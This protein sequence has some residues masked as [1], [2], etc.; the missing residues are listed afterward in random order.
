MPTRSFD[1][2]LDEQL[3]DPEF[4]KGY[5]D[6]C[7]RLEAAVALIR[8]REE[9]HLS[10]EELATLSGINRTTVNRIERGKLNPSMKTLDCLARAMGKT[11]HI[12]IA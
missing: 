12:S 5:T 7:R 2:V 1:S 10:Q 8:A 3:K 6:E 4:A 9:A 11:L